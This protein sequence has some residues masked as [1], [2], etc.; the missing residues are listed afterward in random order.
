MCGRL[1]R[2]LNI[3]WVGDSSLSLALSSCLPCRA[4]QS[5][6]WNVWTPGSVALG[7]C[8]QAAQPLSVLIL[9]LCEMGATVVLTSGQWG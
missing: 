7:S 3:G 4:A 5:P 6:R 8:A 1:E 2:V 9:L